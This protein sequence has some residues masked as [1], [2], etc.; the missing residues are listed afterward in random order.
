MTVVHLMEMPNGGASDASLKKEVTDV[1]SALERILALRPVTWYWKSD[2]DNE[3]L[4]HGFIAQEL[5]RVF[6]DLVTVKEWDDGTSRKHVSVKALVPYLVKAL[7]EQQQR[8]D[9]LE[10][11][12]ET[13]RERM[14]KKA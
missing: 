6:P 7:G 11:E 14:V 12:L 13:L 1:E 3:E 5:E 2:I 9:R 10:Q 8:I 4:E